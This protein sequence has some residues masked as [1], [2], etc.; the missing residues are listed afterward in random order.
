LDSAEYGSHKKLCK[1]FNQA[2]RISYKRFITSMDDWMAGYNPYE[3]R[4]RHQEAMALLNRHKEDLAAMK[5]NLDAAISQARV[6]A[7]AHG[8]YRNEL[9]M[10]LGKRPKKTTS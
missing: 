4:M 1:R 9:Q 8:K 2:V 10:R 7:K 3:V 5:S 6:A